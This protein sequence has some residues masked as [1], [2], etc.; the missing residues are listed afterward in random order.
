[1]TVGREGRATIVCEQCGTR[2]DEGESFCGQ[3]GT[4]LEWE[5]Q[6]VRD[7]EPPAAAPV[8]PAPTAPEPDPVPDGDRASERS[9]EPEPP[10]SRAAPLVAPLIPPEPAAA[11]SRY[12]RWRARR[13]RTAP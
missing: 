8:I 4:Y 13:P 9:G 3:C 5:G 11:G 12:A 10:A 2:N 7:Q 1:M 6:P